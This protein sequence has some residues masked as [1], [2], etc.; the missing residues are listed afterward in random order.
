MIGCNPQTTRNACTATVASAH[1]VLG[2]LA[3]ACVLSF[4]STR[5]YAAPCGELPDPSACPLQLHS[6]T[7]RGLAL[8]T[9]ARASAV[10]TSALAYNPAALVLGKLY[11][12]EGSVDYMSPWSDVA[13]GAAVVDSATS[14]V[15]AGI[16][17][18][19]FI[20]GDNGASG[21]DGRAGLA[22]PFSDAVSIGLGGRY[23][24]VDYEGELEDG[25]RG[26]YELASGF[27]MDA[28]IRVAPVPMFQLQL[29]A[30]N[31]IDLE[32]AY[33]PVLLGGGAAV[34]IAQMATIG[35]DLLVD[36]STFET[37]GVIFGA[38]AEVLVAQLVPLRLGYS[39]DTK[40]E[41]HTLSGGAGYTDRAVGFDLSIQQQLTNDKDTRV[42]GA[43]RFYVQ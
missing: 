14:R 37:A 21:I 34:S 12:I 19:G 13:L 41:L 43:F 2:A 15:G 6:D 27:T 17:F 4:I 38:G 29:L 30:Q 35:A 39:F 31:F 24:N 16:A 3:C 8:G 32:T 5:A 1:R 9:G 22:F 20:S 28:A 42:I 7:A 23:M 26:S 36:V 18:R 40:R 11:H 10:S 33:A 25:S